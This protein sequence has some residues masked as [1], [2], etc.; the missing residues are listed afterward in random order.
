MAIFA[1][2]FG[3]CIGLIEVAKSRTCVCA[4]YMADECEAEPNC[5]WNSNVGSGV[6]RSFKLI[7]CHDD[8]ECTIKERNKFADDL[9]GDDDYDW[10]W[11]CDT[12]SYAAQSIDVRSLQLAAINIDSAQTDIESKIISAQGQSAS[13]AAYLSVDTVSFVC[14]ITFIIV[15]IGAMVAFKCKGKLDNMAIFVNKHKNTEYTMLDDTV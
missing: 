7:E 4:E 13:A 12:M 5:E 15:A 8:W 10:P 6:C 9:M 2:A 1:V 11:D 14:G 3:M